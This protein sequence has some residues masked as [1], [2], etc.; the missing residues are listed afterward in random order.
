[1]FTLCA[2]A[3]SDTQFAVCD[4]SITVVLSFTRFETLNAAGQ[5][6]LET[7]F[8]TDGL[9][10]MTVA[11]AH[12]APAFLNWS[13]GNL[14]SFASGARLALAFGMKLDA[15]AYNGC[16]TIKSGFLRVQ[17]KSGAWEQK[18]ILL[19]GSHLLSRARV[20]QNVAPAAWAPTV[21][22]N[23]NISSHSGWLQINGRVLEVNDGRHVIKL[24]GGST[25][26]VADWEKAIRKAIAGIGGRTAA[27]LLR[28]NRKVL[29]I[30]PWV[31]GR[32][33]IDALM[34][35]KQGFD[36]LIRGKQL[37]LAMHLLATAEHYLLQTAD[38]SKGIVLSKQWEALRSG[39]AK[40]AKIWDKVEGQEFGMEDPFW[41]Y[42]DAGQRKVDW[43][44]L[45]AIAALRACGN[46]TT[47][48]GQLGIHA[49]RL[50]RLKSV[51]A[52]EITACLTKTAT[53]FTAIGDDGHKH[54]LELIAVGHRLY[55]DK[56]W[57]DARE[58][59]K[60]SG[61]PG[62]CALF[63]MQ[64]MIAAD[65][66]TA[67][68]VEAFAAAINI[69]LL[70]T[71]DGAVVDT[72]WGN[73]GMPAIKPKF[74]YAIA[75]TMARLMNAVLMKKDVFMWAPIAHVERGEAPK[76]YMDANSQWSGKWFDA[77]RRRK[78]N[79]VAFEAAAA[80]VF[81]K[82]P[83]TFLQ[84]AVRLCY[85][86]RLPH[87]PLPG[88]NFVREL[89]AND[90]KPA[91]NFGMKVSFKE[92]LTTVLRT[93][94]AAGSGLAGKAAI[95]AEMQDIMKV[96]F[97]SALRK[98]HIARVDKLLAA[99]ER[100]FTAPLVKALRLQAVMLY[101]R[102]VKQ[103]VVKLV[104]PVP[105]V[106][107]LP[108]RLIRHRSSI[109]NPASTSLAEL[110]ENIRGNSEL[111]V[112][113]CWFLL[114]PAMPFM[115]AILTQGGWP[116]LDPAQ[117]AEAG[118]VTL[119]TQSR[120]WNR[121]VF[122]YRLLLRYMWYQELRDTFSMQARSVNRLHQKHSSI[123][124]SVSRG[125]SLSYR[126][127]QEDDFD[128]QQVLVDR[129]GLAC[130][131]VRLLAFD[132]IVHITKLH[133]MVINCIEEIERELTLYA[134]DEENQLL[135]LKQALA[136]YLPETGTQGQRPRHHVLRKQ[137]TLR[138]P[139]LDEILNAIDTSAA[140]FATEHD[141]WSQGLR[142]Q[143]DVER[144][145]G[146]WNYELDRHFQIFVARNPVIAKM[147]HE[148]M[149]A[150]SGLT[151]SS[152]A[153]AKTFSGLDLD[154]GKLMLERDSLRK[155]HVEIFKEDLAMTGSGLQVPGGN[156]GAEP[157]EIG[158][159]ALPP[160]EILDISQQ[161]QAVFHDEFR[162]RGTNEA[163]QDKMA[164]PIVKVADGVSISVSGKPLLDAAIGA[165]PAAAPKAVTPLAQLPQQFKL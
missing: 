109:Q 6:K 62:L 115:E 106:F 56:K 141:Q 139:V 61:K 124:A 101:L 53:T 118:D 24:Q 34:A 152:A 18:E 116:S 42:R 64:I 110:E 148:A 14:P 49:A 22:L 13:R 60:A 84:N 136:L 46:E 8:S 81:K 4:G 27:A 149:P 75:Y 120:D 107:E 132:D 16:L 44:H 93:H 76:K 128:E 150:S 5:M 88:V 50:D 158:F 47:L 45:E 20:A 147:R 15:A 100:L 2:H 59:Y 94:P 89:L 125:E 28:C 66:D 7:P 26:D 71:D 86:A 144:A 11:K 129:I 31:R 12:T 159:D 153:G 32:S 123:V 80:G 51:A 72:L 29:Q 145:Y 92:A 33:I 165:P 63:A 82:A 112:R 48:Q 142:Q 19:R 39:A 134:P 78:L 83:D 73:D 151:K 38:G 58:Y 79:K 155:S 114:H 68:A 9:V 25:A 65:A 105:D 103:S 156:P 67:T 126:R 122:P 163:R 36:E 119:L 41:G 74:D 77:L 127:D 70:Q 91:T 54:E 98:S 1:M 108:A 102:V 137:I 97:V 154:Q 87:Q 55:F 35:V 104:L 160:A 131:A 96:H 40:M 30:L 95:D 21:K 113:Q 52:H 143:T 10:K 90:D 161:K 117:A 133:E 43:S 140:G 37:Y 99:A 57:T 69:A 135:P 162:K 85:C 17:V 111:L 121:F 130:T 157:F 164:A 3:S 138:C 146:M 23:S